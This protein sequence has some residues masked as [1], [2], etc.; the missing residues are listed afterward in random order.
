MKQYK[1]RING[2]LYNVVINNIGDEIAEVE[3]NGTPYKVEVEKKVKKPIPSPFKKP[4]QAGAPNP[5]VNKPVAKHTSQASANA[6]KSPLPGIILDINC[7]VGDKVKKGQKLLILEAM[8]MENNIIAD[9][10]GTIQEV[11]VRKGDSVLEGSELVVI[12]G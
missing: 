11:K 3:V 7:N 5:E 1:Y 4:A 9:K 2:S 12:V 6:L 10:D 8:K